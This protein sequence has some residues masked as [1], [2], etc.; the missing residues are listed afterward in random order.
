[1]RG[2]VAARL[3]ALAPGQL[4]IVEGAATWGASGSIDVLER[5]T[6]ALGQDL[7]VEPTVQSLVDE[8]IFSLDLDRWQFRSDSVREVAYGRLTKAERH[9]RHDG[10]ASYLAAIYPDPPSAPDGVLDVVARHYGL[11]ADLADEYG[12]GTTETAARA[13]PWLAEAA[14]RASQ[15]DFHPMAAKLHGHVLRLMDPSAL[16]SRVDHLIAQATALLELWEVDEAQALVEEAD[17]LTARLSDPAQAA[18][19]EALRG[20]LQLR[21]GDLEQAEVSYR[22]AMDAFLALGDR[23]GYADARRRLGMHRMFAQDLDAAEHHITEALAAY[24]EVGHRRGQAWALQNLAWIAFISG[25]ARE[26]ERWAR[27]SADR[28]SELGDSGGFAWATGLLAF[29]LFHL[30][31]SAQALRLGRRVLNDAQERGDQWG[32]G[33]MR[34]LLASIALFSHGDARSAVDHAQH[35]LRRF[36]NTTDSDASAQ[37]AGTLGR[38]QLAMGDVSAAFE[39]LDPERVPRGLPTAMITTCRLTAAAHIGDPGMVA[40]LVDAETADQLDPASLGD[41]DRLVAIGMLLAQAGRV[42]D[43]RHALAHALDATADDTSP[44]AMSASALCAAVAHRQEQCHEFAEVVFNEPRSTYLDRTI[45]Q[46]ALML[47][48]AAAGDES[49]VAERFELAQAEVDD[50]EDRPAQ[51]LVR[52]LGGKAFNAVGSDRGRV[53]SDDAE[54]RLTWLGLTMPGWGVVADAALGPLAQVG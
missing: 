38:A 14:G 1:L 52:L 37:A 24:E 41:R 44:Y 42:D 8:E 4:T 9:K 35:A 32:E 20:D 13:L 7:D 16:S 22:R 48:A 19:V 53:V 30:G 36:G 54:T 27:A 6:E 31:D 21:S 29:V 28:F 17:G 2:I 10:I 49:E 50:V 12:D 46:L 39:T 33:M 3:D 45:A 40:D 34:V 11:A 43:A 26:A 5:M 15:R 23:T 18:R 47:S 25:R 51:A